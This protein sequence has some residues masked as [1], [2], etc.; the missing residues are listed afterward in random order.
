MDF[1]PDGTK[2]LVVIG[3]TKSI[4]FIDTNTHTLS[5]T[6]DVTTLGYDFPN[7]AVFSLDGSQVIFSASD[8]DHKVVFFNV[9]SSTVDGAVTVPPGGNNIADVVC[10]N[11][12]VPT[13]TPTPTPIPTPTPTT[14]VFSELLDKWIDWADCEADDDGDGV[15]NCNDYFP[16]D[17]GLSEKPEGAEATDTPG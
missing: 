4:G 5:T 10:R 6:F 15:V 14:Y 12:V 1:S 8:G 16:S 11:P 3:P 13:P 2:A 17:Y 9:A 7:D